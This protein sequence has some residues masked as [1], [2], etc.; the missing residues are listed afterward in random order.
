MSF[1]GACAARK[2]A[3]GALGGGQRLPRRAVGSQPL[4]QMGELC[5]IL[6]Y[7]AGALE[8]GPF[9]LVQDY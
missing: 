7:P 8:S 6:Q 2:A 3:F 1:D 4:M 9:A 5:F